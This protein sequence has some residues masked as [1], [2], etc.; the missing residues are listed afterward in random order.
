MSTRVNLLYFDI[1]LYPTVTDWRVWRER[2]VVSFSAASEMKLPPANYFSASLALK[3][4][5][6]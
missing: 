3:R 5:F 6:G 1:D 4:L 2:G